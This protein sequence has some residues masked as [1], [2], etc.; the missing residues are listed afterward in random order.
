MQCFQ[1]MFS[2]SFDSA[3]TANC[4]ALQLHFTL[5][6]HCISRFFL[7][8]MAMKITKTTIKRLATIRN[9]LAPM[10]KYALTNP[11]SAME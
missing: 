4:V 9:S 2:G 6:D 3:I 1:V 10:V 8:T 11:V 7:Q 5:G